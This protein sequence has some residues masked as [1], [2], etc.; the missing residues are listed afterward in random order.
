MLCL[1]WDWG[2]NCWSMDRNLDGLSG[3][4][5]R[6]LSRLGCLRQGGSWGHRDRSLQK[7]LRGPRSCQSGE[8]VRVWLRRCWHLRRGSSCGSAWQWKPGDPGSLG[9]EAFCQILKTAA[10]VGQQLVG[11]GAVC[12]LSGGSGQKLG[13]DPSTLGL[14]REPEAKGHLCG[15]GQCGWGGDRLGWWRRPR[16]QL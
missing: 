14:S 12:C 16:H 10:K 1:L 9:R 2:T 3:G 13:R 15:P 11:R 4:L 5:G 8:E 7:P 6:V